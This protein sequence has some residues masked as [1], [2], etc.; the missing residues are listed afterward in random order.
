MVSPFG[1]RR[2]KFSTQS[3]TGK[4]QPRTALAVAADRVAA[5]GYQIGELMGHPLQALVPVERHSEFAA[6]LQ[7]IIC[8]RSDSGE[9][10]LQA[11]DGRHLIWQYHNMLDDE[12]E[13]A[14]VIGHAQDITERERYERTLREWSVRDPLTG[15][16]NRRHLGDLAASM[17]EEDVWGCIAVDLDRFKQ[18]N[19][20][21]GHQRGD[22]VL[23]AMGKFLAR[24]VRPDDVVVR[25]GGD[26]FL[27]L[28]K[29]ADAGM[30]DVVCARMLEHHA[31]APIGF[32]LGRSVRRQGVPL[33]AALEAADHNLYQ[34]RARA[35]S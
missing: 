12:D 22:E 14:Y 5:L 13:D 33:Q 19:D 30:T 11:R 32:T 16:Y 31:D 27:M 34:V 9:L 18:V 4:P 15:L 1:I 6:Y 17:S 8:N 10:H 3:R 7:R 24:Q 29:G 26:E 23:V 28:L 25:S 20:V 35:R 2:S 21:H